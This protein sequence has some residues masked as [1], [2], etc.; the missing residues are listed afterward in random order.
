MADSVA[1]KHWHALQKLRSPH[2]ALHY[3][4]TTYQVYSTFH[5]C[6]LQDPLQPNA[7]NPTTVCIFNLKEGSTPTPIPN[8][9]VCCR[10]AHSLPY[11]HKY[12]ALAVNLNVR[13][14]QVVESHG[15]YLNKNRLHK[16][17]HWHPNESVNETQNY[18]AVL[19]S[20]SICHSNI[21]RY[22]RITFP[23]SFA[24]PKQTF[25]KTRPWRY[26]RA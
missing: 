16:S 9:M 11:L 12:K 18:M 17:T 4:E 15:L 26:T 1:F 21:R 23:F 25:S 7:W 6:C 14:P 13:T 8:H 24:A 5:T 3:R 22:N 10:S 19:H 2:K 20:A